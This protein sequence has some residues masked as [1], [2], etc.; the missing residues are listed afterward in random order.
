MGSV[1]PPGRRKTGT[2]S[3]SR[4]GRTRRRKNGIDR[5]NTCGASSVM[6]LL[7]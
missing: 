1:H 4:A 7:V 2:V 5:Q 6:G 3:L